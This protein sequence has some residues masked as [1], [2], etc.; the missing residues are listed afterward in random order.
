M[1]K[2][3]KYFSNGLERV[4]YYQELMKDFLD[5]NLNSEQKTI[6]KANADL[7]KK[8]NDYIDSYYYFS[9]L[10]YV[11]SL[12]IQE[13][14]D[15]AA[16]S[17]YL[18]IKVSCKEQYHLF[19][20]L[21][22]ALKRAPITEQR[23]YDAMNYSIKKSKERL[24]YLLD[25]VIFEYVK[26]TPLYDYYNYLIKNGSSLK[27]NIV[28]CIDF[29]DV[30]NIANDTQ[31]QDYLEKIN[32]IL[33]QENSKEYLIN[34]E[35]YIERRERIHQI[36]LKEK[37]ERLE[38]KKLQSIEKAQKCLDDKKNKMFK[39]FDNG[40]CHYYLSN[41]DFSES[42]YSLKE[43]GFNEFKFILISK[44]NITGAKSN[45]YLQN[46]GTLSKT[47]TKNCILMPTYQM[48]KD[49]LNQ[50]KNGELLESEGICLI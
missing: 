5:T 46:D 32:K 44:P 47:F 40:R 26:I 50:I 3:R 48:P 43:N 24:D 45:W 30:N 6:N 15:K 23:Y 27:E 33:E 35:K 10:T 34:L 31:V 25:N 49:L 16:F 19:L 2:E 42:E 1:V 18:R 11:I 7:I 41:K 38:K 28:E 14:L 21:K 20:C 9:R 29:D 13:Y 36:N 37:E 22:R 4:K 39:N 17:N 12:I 8:I